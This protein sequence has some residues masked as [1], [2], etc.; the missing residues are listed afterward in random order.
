M[1][2]ASGEQAVSG[3]CAGEEPLC[4]AREEVDVPGR[5]GSHALCLCR[6]NLVVPRAGEE[7]A[8]PE[9]VRKEEGWCQG[10]WICLGEQ[11]TSGW[12][13]ARVAEALKP[14]RV[15]KNRNNPLSS[16]M[17][18]EGLKGKFEG[19]LLLM[20][21]VGGPCWSAFFALR[22]SKI[23]QTFGDGPRWSCS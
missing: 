9:R 15:K 19:L 10:C 22:P 8:E 14:A 1:G 2:P 23:G 3:G 18:I 16:P 20:A 13:E 11:G 6:S 4:R 7:G 5:R 21:E 17:T 12:W